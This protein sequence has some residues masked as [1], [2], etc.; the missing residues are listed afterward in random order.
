M[1][2]IINILKPAGMTSQQVVSRV[3]RVLGVKKAGHTGTLDPGVPGV[4]PICLGRATKVAQYLIE[5]D[6]SYRGE[7]TF[8]IS[9][10]SQDLFGST[11]RECDASSLSSEEISQAFQSF[12]GPIM[13]IPPMFSA[14]RVQGKR[15]YELARQGLEVERKA[16]EAVIYNLD[17]IS[18]TQLGTPRPKV[19]FDV[20]CSKGTYIRTLCADIGDKLGTGGV[21][22]SLLRTK[23][24]PFTLENGVTLEQLEQA[25]DLNT[26]GELVTPIDSVLQHMPAIVVKD[27]ALERTQNGNSLYLPGIFRL[28]D[29]DISSGKIVRLYSE[30]GQLLAIAKAIPNPLHPEQLYFQPETVF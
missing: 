17:I 28:P 15:L 8:G 27:S 1:N 5:K 2:G 23:S 22:S 12:V 18:I 25:V 30:D 9:T 21:M 4:L 11:V 16:R 24:G 3:R 14:V 20:K 26:Q 7:L 6:K 13:Q 29:N 19:L 10:D